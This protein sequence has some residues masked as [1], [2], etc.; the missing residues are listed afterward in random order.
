MQAQ[1]GGRVGGI[2]ISG[3]EILSHSVQII[4]TFYHKNNKSIGSFVH[5]HCRNDLASWTKGL[6]FHAKEIV[7]GYR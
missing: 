6:M 4:V 1:A 5:S 3:V 2:G 7:N